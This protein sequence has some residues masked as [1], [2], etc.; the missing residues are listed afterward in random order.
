MTVCFLL[1][2]KKGTKNPPLSGEDVYFY[3]KLQILFLTLNH[4]KKIIYRRIV[5]SAAAS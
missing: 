5:N 4:C 3:A 2:Q 1:Y